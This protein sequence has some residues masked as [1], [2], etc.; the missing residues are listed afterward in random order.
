MDIQSAGGGRMT[1]GKSDESAI[2]LG[3]V[4][5]NGGHTAE[6]F[7]WILSFLYPHS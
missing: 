6:E 1:E 3:N 2:V 4:T 5:G 7:D